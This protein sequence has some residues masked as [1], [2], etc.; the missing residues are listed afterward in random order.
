M[1]RETAQTSHTVKN[2]R[3]FQSSPSMQRETFVSVS[4]FCIINKIS[5]LSLYAEGDVIFFIKGP[6]PLY[7]NPLPLCRG[8]PLWRSC[9]RSADSRF[10]SSPSMQRE[11][12]ESYRTIPISE[13]SILSLY[14]EGDMCKGLQ[15]EGSRSFQSSPS[16]QRETCF[17]VASSIFSTISILS[18][19]AEGDE[20][21][22]Y[23]D[24]DCIVISILSL[25]AEGDNNQWEHLGGGGVISILSLYAEGDKQISF[26]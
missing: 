5:I 22:T 25:Y 18:L 12:W 10:Q 17:A 11:T 8:R 21:D 9:S 2:R 3:L 1:Q 15:R 24:G 16:M 7:F 26:H 6:L 20:R 19:Y 4:V 14:A 23:H 13:I